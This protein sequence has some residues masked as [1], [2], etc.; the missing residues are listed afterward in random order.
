M[1][2]VE[3]ED[4]ELYVSP[5]VSGT[6]AEMY[7]GPVSNE[8]FLP[9]FRIKDR[10]GDWIKAQIELLHGI[11]LKAHALGANTI[12]G[13]EIIL[14][15]FARDHKDRPGMRLYASGTAAKLVPLF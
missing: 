1:D 6:R 2:L 7:Y 4:I 13:L 11:R 5:W 10:E 9:D 3:I 8:M 15:P 14:D 12:V